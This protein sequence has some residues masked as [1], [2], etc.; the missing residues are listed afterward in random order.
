MP[1]AASSP[2]SNPDHPII[3]MS[4][5]ITKSDIC[6]IIVKFMGLILVY[7]TCVLIYT[8]ILGEIVYQEALEALKGS[9]RDLP[10]SPARIALFRILII[11]PLG[12]YLLTAGRAIHRLLMKVP[13]HVVRTE[14]VGKAQDITPSEIIGISKAELEQ[15]KAWLANNPAVK[16]Q[17]VEDQVAL[18]RDAQ[19]RE[20]R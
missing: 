20:K 6:W 17:D 19:K 8:A 16:K 15:F 5:P 11:L 2:Y 10:P 1:M 7:Q 14:S 18:F 13:T 4:H 3:S 12:L 9:T